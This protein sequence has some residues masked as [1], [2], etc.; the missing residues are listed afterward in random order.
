MNNGEINLHSVS[1]ASFQS[2]LYEEK[3]SI[4]NIVSEKTF[5]NVENE[6]LQFCRM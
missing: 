3:I 6:F 5:F 2:S 1:T 4:L